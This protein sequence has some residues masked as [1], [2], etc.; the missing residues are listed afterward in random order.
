MVRLR[1]QS[2][3]QR[4]GSKRGKLAAGLTIKNFSLL[5]IFCCREFF[6]QKYRN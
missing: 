4:L 3:H 5:K 6:F 1:T 2:L